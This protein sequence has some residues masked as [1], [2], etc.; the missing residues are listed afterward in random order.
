MVIT[1][2]LKL[3]D[4]QGLRSRIWT[5]E[6]GVTVSPLGA[7]EGLIKPPSLRKPREGVLLGEG[8][9][10]TH[11]GLGEGLWL[12]FSPLFTVHKLQP[13]TVASSDIFLCFNNNNNNNKKVCQFSVII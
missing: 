7:L 8:C 13:F 5:A 11:T 10:P 9:L 3:L 6:L 12:D 4:F 2:F 1:F